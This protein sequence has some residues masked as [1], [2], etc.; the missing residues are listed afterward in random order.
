MTCA[1]AVVL[2]GVTTRPARLGQEEALP[3]GTSTAETSDE[4]LAPGARVIVPL[5]G[6]LRVA[7]MTWAPVLS[8]PATPGNPPV[9]H[10]ALEVFLST[11]GVMMWP[12]APEP[13]P[14]LIVSVVV[15]HWGVPAAVVVVALAVVVVVGRA[16]VEVVVELERVRAAG[17][18]GK[19]HDADGEGDEATVHGPTIRLPAMRRWGWPAS[20]RARRADEDALISRSPSPHEGA[21]GCPGRTIEPRGEPMRSLRLTGIAAVGGLLAI[22][23]ASAGAAGASGSGGRAGPAGI[24]LA[25]AAST[26]HGHPTPANHGHGRGG[27]HKGRSTGHSHTGSSQLEEPGALRAAPGDAVVGLSWTAPVTSLT[28]S[29]Y[30]LQISTDGTT[31]STLVDQLSGTTY[32]ATGLTDGTSYLFRVAAE[33]TSSLGEF[34]RP[35]DATP[36]TNPPVATVPGAVGFARRGVR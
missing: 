11:S 21:L 9:T 5:L 19:S 14:R 22:A 26:S 34:S 30:Q 4:A 36:S 18:G 16:V 27:K 3:E 6:P 1:E 12:A 10:G 24:E 13:C 31:W 15:E 28:I 35:V 32:Q 20:A 29:G 7:W 25:A 8:V 17:G 33:T 2:G 23:G